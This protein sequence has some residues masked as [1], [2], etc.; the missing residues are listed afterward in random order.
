MVVNGGNFGL[1]IVALFGGTLP[2]DKIGWMV[3]F[4]ANGLMEHLNGDC[5]TEVAL[6]ELLGISRPALR[7]R[8]QKMADFPVQPVDGRPTMWPRG[9]AMK[10]ARDLGLQLPEI[11]KAEAPQVGE[12]VTVASKPVA[13]G[14]HFLNPNVIQVKRENGELVYLRVVD[15][16][17]YLPHLRGT[18]KPM[19]LRAAPSPSGNWWTLLGREPRFVGAW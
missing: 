13:H 7:A 9:L 6:S 19:T 18:T 3:H 1:R 11:P 16:S 5:I 8:R 4:L 17:K 12:I 10:V 2:I 14:R 15:S